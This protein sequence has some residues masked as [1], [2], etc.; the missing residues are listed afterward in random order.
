[1]GKPLRALI[2]EDSEDDTELMAH[3]LRHGGYDLTYRRVDTAAAM[4]AALCRQTWDI[5]LADHTM[6][7]FSVPAALSLLQK[8]EP[9][10]PLIIVSGTIS[11]DLAKAA[12]RAGAHGYVTKD[13]L[14]QLVPA[15]E[16][17][18]REAAEE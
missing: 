14:S 16:S 8:R 15:I 4:D 3:E 6:T 12:V 17:S 10:L 2:I 18:L 5:A 11:E 7:N 1:M 13:N 9:D